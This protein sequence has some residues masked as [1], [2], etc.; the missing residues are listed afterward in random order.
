MKS[1]V[2]VFIILPGIT[3][4]HIVESLL[5]LTCCISFL[6]VTLISVSRWVYYVDG[7]GGKQVYSYSCWAY[8]CACTLALLI[9]HSV[10]ICIAFANPRLF[11][12]AFNCVL[13]VSLLRYHRL[14][15]ITIVA[16]CV[17]LCNIVVYPLL[18]LL[19]PLSADLCSLFLRTGACSVLLMHM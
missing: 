3:V 17:N 1:N 8:Q 10:R 12:P 13:S 4:Y 9:Y 14:G 15:M 6:S 16:L 2:K 18:F 5:C 7:K 19:R 11:S